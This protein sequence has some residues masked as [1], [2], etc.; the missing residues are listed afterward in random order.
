MFAAWMAFA[1]SAAEYKE[2]KR[3]EG[4]TDG[5]FLRALWE[6]VYFWDFLKEFGRCTRDLA[7]ISVGIDPQKRAEEKEMEKAGGEKRVR[8][9]LKK[10]RRRK[11]RD[12]SGEPE[13]KRRRREKSESDW[14]SVTSKRS[15]LT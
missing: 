15:E 1:Y 9:K 7:L 14:D 13:R 5:G 6:S 4:R 10:K 11:E 2:L 8:N 3:E 12:R